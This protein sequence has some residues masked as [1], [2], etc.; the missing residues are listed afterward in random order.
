MTRVPKEFKLWKKPKLLGSLKILNLSYCKIVRVEGFSW[1]PALERS[2]DADMGFT[3]MVSFKQ[4]P[5]P[6][7][8]R[9]WNI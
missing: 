9:I 8:L 6:D 4:S 3:Q 2:E 5:S 1:L 7:E